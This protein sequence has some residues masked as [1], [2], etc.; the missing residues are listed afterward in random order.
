MHNMD[1]YEVELEKFINWFADLEQIPGETRIDFLNHILEV[2][3]MDEKAEKFV[4]DSL[5]HLV[6]GSQQ[7]ADE[8]KRRFE[9]LE[10][11][12]AG[13]EDPNLSLAEHVLHDAE[14]KMEKLAG[15]L[16]TDFI[17]FEK[18]KSVEAETIEQTGEDSEVEAL[19]KNL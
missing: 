15:G 16:K 10:G 6:K 4:T 5:D 17:E 7:E 13:Q 8:L 3:Y 1:N 12:V 14:E 19:K 2:G 9:V 11:A 18:E